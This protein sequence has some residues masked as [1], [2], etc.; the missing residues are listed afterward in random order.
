MKIQKLIVAVVC[1]ATFAIGA[2]KF[3]TTTKVAVSV[4]R[5]SVA[6]ENLSGKVHDVYVTARHAD[7]T[8]YAFRHVHNLRTNAGADAQASQMANTAAQA[9]SC[10]YIAVSND[11]AAPAAGDTTLASEIAANGLTRAQGTYSHSNGTASFT[12]TKVFSVSGTQSSQKTGVFNAASVGTMCW[13]AAYS[14][15]TNNIGD[16]LTISWTVNY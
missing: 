6:T 8:V 3:S 4:G 7:G 10:N 15:I 5:H 9:A 14:Q 2:E 1:L 13:E 12:V 11:A 16:T